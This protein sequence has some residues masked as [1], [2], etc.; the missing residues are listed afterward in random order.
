MADMEPEKI[1]VELQKV[2]SGAEDSA[3]SAERKWEEVF[4]MWIEKLDQSNMMPNLFELK[5]WFEGMEEFN[6]SSYLESLVFKTQGPLDRSYDFFLSIFQQVTTRVIV[7]L[8]ELDFKKDKFFLN[9]EEFIVEKLLDGFMGT[10]YAYL[11][12]VYTPESW[13]YSFRIFLQH[14]RILMLDLLKSESISQKV[15]NAVKK[16]YHRELVN[17]P[18]LITL[19]KNQFIPRMDR[20]SFPDISKIIAG[21]KD[22]QLKKELGIFFVLS[23]RITK[24]IE[25][26]DMHMNKSRSLDM[27]VP[28]LLMLKRSMENL[29]QFANRTLLPSLEKVYSDKDGILDVKPT[30]YNLVFEIKKIFDGELPSYFEVESNKMGKRRTVKNMLVIS[31]FAMEEMIASVALLLN[32]DIPIRVIFPDYVP[33]HD[34]LGE[35]L[36]KLKFM[37]DKINYYFVRKGNVESSEI[38]LDVQLFMERDL[39]FLYYA[40]WN[41]FK[42]QYQKLSLAAS[43]GDFEPVLR[44]F[45]T[46]IG[47]LG[48]RKS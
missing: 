17:N 15:L 35:A 3:N 48:K 7:L 19:M 21:T 47:D 11:R 26:I 16:L 30:F 45:H 44:E 38:I 37:Y 10:S 43:P 20:I 12:Q 40:K 22:R 23:F 6:S 33:R 4:G 27:I 39:H 5:L 34:L 9:F 42:A 8:K 32:T 25:I 18:M 13:F 24:I 28:L 46:F 1:E 2:D 29:D 36:K 14:Y 31:R 41:E